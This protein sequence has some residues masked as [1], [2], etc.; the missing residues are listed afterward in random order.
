[1]N[2]EYGFCPWNQIHR[3]PT[4]FERA[5]LAK[6]HQFGLK[7]TE[8]VQDEKKKSLWASNMWWARCRLR[9]YFIFTRG[10]F[11][12]VLFRS[13]QGEWWRR[14]DLLESRAKNHRQPG[15]RIWPWGVDL[16]PNHRTFPMPGGRSLAM[17]LQ[18]DVRIAMDP[19]LEPRFLLLF[20][21]SVYWVILSMISHGMLRWREGLE[22]KRG[23]NKFSFSSLGPRSKGSCT[24]IW[25]GI[26]GSWLQA[27]CRDWAS[28]MRMRVF[29]KWEDLE[30]LWPRE[31]L[32]GGCISLFPTPCPSSSSFLGLL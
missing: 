4:I 13:D 23:A 16:E 12:S 15:L 22:G 29:C 21:G 20:D 6:A 8:T 32:V 26:W 9:K 28:W 3:K 2:C 14:K 1:M 25:L 31:Q 24:G 19:W 11:S 7:D 18:W 17:F 5:V 10:I 27:W 30:E